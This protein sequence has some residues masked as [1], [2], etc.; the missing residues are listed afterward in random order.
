MIP[1]KNEENQSYHKQSI[2][3]ICKIK[4]STNDSN[5][6]PFTKYLNIR[7]HCHYDGKYRGAA[8]NI[9]NLR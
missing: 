7:D 2:C 3:Y 1:L 8:H 9:C 5:G 6:V 4:F